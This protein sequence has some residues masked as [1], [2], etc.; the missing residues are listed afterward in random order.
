MNESYVELLVKRKRQIGTLIGQIFLIVLSFISAFL[1]LLTMSIF[2]LLATLIFGGLAYLLK[3]NG[4][5]EYEYLLLDKELSIDKIKCQSGRKKAAEYD[6]TNL[7]LLAPVSSH[8]MDA[9]R[10]R[11]DIKT[12]DF[13][14]GERDGAPYALIIRTGG[15]LER[16]LIECNDDLLDHISRFAPRKVFKD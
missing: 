16:V 10:E 1:F 15:A 2:L 14:T 6:L 7:E 5:V 11:R 3:Y 8:R 12:K 13:S 4:N 9:Y